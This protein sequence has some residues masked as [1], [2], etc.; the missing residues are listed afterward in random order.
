MKFNYFARLII[1]FYFVVCTVLDLPNKN[2]LHN[3]ESNR[4]LLDPLEEI[5]ANL[6]FDFITHFSPSDVVETPTYQ[7]F[8]RSVRTKK[9]MAVNESNSY[10]S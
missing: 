5:S 1:Q 3:I 10:V 7:Q 6:G 9:H 4:K 2:Y 8:M